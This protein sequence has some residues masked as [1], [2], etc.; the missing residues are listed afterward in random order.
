MA[1]ALTMTQPSLDQVTG[2]LLGLAVGDAV[3]A[4]VE[5]HPPEDARRYAE[6]IL[7]TG[8]LPERGREAFPFGQV[9]DDTQL[10]RELL[11]SVGADGAF[12]PGRF[13]TRLLNLVASGRFVGGGPAAHAAARQLALGVPWHDAGLPAPYAGNGAAMRAAPLGLLYGHD[14]RLLARVVADQA[15]VTH[16]D[17]R[18]AA[19]AL[20]VATAAW[21]AARREPVRPVEFLV[22]VSRAVE[23]IDPGTATVVWD[24]GTWAHL[25]PDQAAGMLQEHEPEARGGWHGIS[26]F[27]TSSV[28]WSLYAFLQAPDDYWEAVCIAIQV[29]GDTDTLGAMTGAIVGGRLGTGAIPARYRERLTDHGAWGPGELAALADRVAGYV[30]RRTP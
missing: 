7:R 30:M 16:Q 2:S 23:P 17:P 13:A 9:T 11:L 14:P 10:A 21:L 27:V 25:P 1:P 19:G 26:S 5:A 12:D 4:V 18:A 15:R 24:M 6:T 20:G 28:C 22:E 3:G 8:R 29:G